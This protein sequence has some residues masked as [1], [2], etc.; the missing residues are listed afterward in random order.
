[1][2]IY[3]TLMEPEESNRIIVFSVVSPK[4]SKQVISERIAACPGVPTS[5]ESN[6]AGVARSPVLIF[7]IANVDDSHLH[8]VFSMNEGKVV[9]GGDVSGRRQQGS[10]WTIETCKPVDGGVR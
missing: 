4:V 7:S 3:L 8:R 9:A 5:V 1:R 10:R 6:V 2:P